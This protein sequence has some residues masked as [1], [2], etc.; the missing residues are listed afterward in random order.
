MSNEILRIIKKADLDIIN[1]HG[2]G[3][4]G[5]SNMYSEAVIYFYLY[6]SIR[7]GCLRSVLI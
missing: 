1:C 3:Y 6:N 5:P 7:A 4:V 2:Q